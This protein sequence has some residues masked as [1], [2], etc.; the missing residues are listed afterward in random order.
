MGSLLLAACSSDTEYRYVDSSLPALNNATVT[1]TGSKSLAFYSDAVSYDNGT[2]VFDKSQIEANTADKLVLKNTATGET[3]ATAKVDLTDLDLGLGEID[4]AGSAIPD[5]ADAKESALEALRTDVAAAYD[6]AVETA[7]DGGDLALSSTDLI[8]DDGTAEA[9]QT[10]IEGLI[11]K[12]PGAAAVLAD[13]GFTSNGEKYSY[14]EE[15]DNHTSGSAANALAAVIPALKT[16]LAIGGSQ[17]YETVDAFLSAKGVDVTYTTERIDNEARLVQGKGLQY[18]TFGYVKQYDVNYAD[19]EG[20]PDTVSVDL[21]AGAGV[22]GVTTADLNSYYNVGDEDNAF[23]GKTVANLTVG[24]KNT[25][26]TGTATLT[27]NKGSETLDLSFND[28]YD[29][30]YSTTSAAEIIHKE[31]VAADF[32][33]TGKSDFNEGNNLTV[34]EAEF[35]A[36]YYGNGKTISEAAGIFSAGDDNKTNANQIYDL[37]GAFGGT[38]TA[39]IPLK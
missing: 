26:L 22:P 7:V 2:V 14:A 34:K 19:A 28:W 35:E 24:S 4:S 32:Q 3:T 5:V 18:A 27:F 38:A 6:D 11:E 37:K 36:A 8:V 30:R 10:F 33:L 9:A 15:G 31:G 39:P 20:T 13:Y 16:N 17:G 1:T 12:Y 23:N 21:F 29:V 25:D